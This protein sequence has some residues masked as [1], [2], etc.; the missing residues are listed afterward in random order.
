M[1]SFE[2]LVTIA[3]T[4]IVFATCLTIFIK[5]LRK[6]IVKCVMGASREATQE[7]HLENL[8]CSMQNNTAKLETIGA[9]VYEN[10]EVSKTILRNSIVHL[11]YKYIGSDGMPYY[12]RE[13]LISLYEAYHE[14]LD[15]NSFATNCYEELL[16]KP[17]IK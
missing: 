3:N 14:I 8:N 12:E 16:K 5:P 15:G 4:I 9:D 2:G 10:K 1:E 7:Q 11:Y 17:V 6:G 13:N